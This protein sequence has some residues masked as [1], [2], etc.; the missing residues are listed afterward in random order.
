MIFLL[1]FN[2]YNKFFSLVSH[3]CG[4]NIF[5]KFVKDLKDGSF[6]RDKNVFSIELI[7]DIYGE[8]FLEDIQYQ[9]YNF[10]PIEYREENKKF[11]I[12][13]S[14]YFEDKIKNDKG[15]VKFL[16]F[17][18]ENYLDWADTASLVYQN[19]TSISFRFRRIFFLPSSGRILAY[20]VTNT[21]PGCEDLKGDNPD[22]YEFTILL[23]KDLGSSLQLDY[24]CKKFKD[25][26]NS[27]DYKAS[28]EDRFV[29]VEVVTPVK[30]TLPIKMQLSDPIKL[31]NSGVVKIE[32]FKELKFETLKWAYNNYFHSE[33]L[34][35]GSDLNDKFVTSWVFCEDK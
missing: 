13:V 17:V 28:T 16:S 15:V 31:N 1:M 30:Q 34:L 9:I 11:D 5:F 35:I 2:K 4:F 26:V 12:L 27:E 19:I 20:C 6:G 3:S 8:D 10:D 25:S 7:K 18:D 22:F 14:N 32:N 24:F 23:E 33:Y 21:N 29:Q